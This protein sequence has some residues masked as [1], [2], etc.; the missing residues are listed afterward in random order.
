MKKFILVALLVTTVLLTGCSKKEIKE[1]IESQQT[2]NHDFR[3]VNWGD[4]IE[5]VKKSE[6]I[7]PSQETQNS[8]VYKVSVAN[9]SNVLLVYNFDL[10]GKLYN[11]SYGFDYSTNS[12]QDIK[13]YDILKESL[14]EIYGKPNKDDISKISTM[15]DNPYISTEESL[16][17]GYIEY[18]TMWV[19]DKTGVVLNMSSKNYKTLTS[20]IYIDVNNLVDTKTDKNGL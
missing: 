12:G 14:S 9:E 20:I 7:N 2:E 17:R 4:D 5:T 10:N 13:R 15:A 6:K 16:E 18:S 11:G 8:L 1:V 3:S 19:N